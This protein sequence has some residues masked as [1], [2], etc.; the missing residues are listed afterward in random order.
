MIVAHIIFI[1][2]QEVEFQKETIYNNRYLTATGGKAVTKV[3]E[4]MV[5]DFIDA[6]VS[7][8]AENLIELL[9]K[10]AIRT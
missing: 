1:L 7:D 4:D 8:N 2:L 10:T 5:D 3:K 9:T 6:I